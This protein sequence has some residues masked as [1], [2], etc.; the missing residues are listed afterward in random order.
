[1]GA[2]QEGFLDAL[3]R[4]SNGRLQYLT[5]FRNTSPELAAA[6]RREEHYVETT[7]GLCVEGKEFFRSFH[8]D[9]EG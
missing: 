1:M 7:D 6:A 8:L 2:G 5:V 4:S 3:E 9:M